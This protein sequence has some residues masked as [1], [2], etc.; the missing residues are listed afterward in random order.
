MARWVGGLLVPGSTGDG[1]QLNP[2][3]VREV[4][5]LA[6]EVAAERGLRVWVGVLQAERESILEGLR[7]M[8]DWL[9]PGTAGRRRL[10]ALENR[11]ICGFTVCPP[12][13]SDLTQEEIEDALRAFLSTG[14]PIALY[15][16]PQVTG[17]ELAPAGFAR[18]AGDFPNLMF[19]KDTSG[20]DRVARSGIDMAGIFS[21]RGAEGGY[22][23]WLRK[24]GGPY[25][26]FLLSTA[27]GFAHQ[28]AA[29][30]RGT[31]EGPPEAGVLSADALSVLVG[32][33]F[34]AV[35]KVPEGNAF[36]NAAKA[37]DHFMAHGSRARHQ[38]PPILHSGAR[39][40]EGL[41]LQVGDLLSARGVVP[42]EGYLR[43][44]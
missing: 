8:A 37:V 42:E 15:Q 41:I 26:G 35:S 30:F 9:V 20:V 34:G 11:R 36:A 13:G 38:P 17:N 44:R 33:I 28:L 2:G 40:D 27:N 25:D 22:G 39:L 12:S 5:G 19:F 21:V 23:N 14:L 3:Q 29:I 10:E 4:V 32:E 16:L 6:M 7:E 24:N 31:T 43:M 18:L 1:W